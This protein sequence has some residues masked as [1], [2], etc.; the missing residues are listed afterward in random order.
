MAFG[1]HRAAALR[2]YQKEDILPFEA[3]PASPHMDELQLE[4]V[5]PEQRHEI[6]SGEEIMSLN[7]RGGDRALPCTQGLRCCTQCLGVHGAFWWVDDDV[8]LYN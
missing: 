2:K 6:A 3:P 8:S 7:N 1:A 4:I 5:N